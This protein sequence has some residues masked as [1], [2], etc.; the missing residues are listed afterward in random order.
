M[1]CESCGNSVLDEAYVCPF[2]GKQLKT[3]PDEILTELEPRQP[4]RKFY[5][6]AKIFS[7]VATVLSGITLLCG[8]FSFSLL[9]SAFTFG[10]DGGGILA[11]LSAV[12]GI[13]CMVGFAFFAL[14]TGILAFVFKKKSLQPTGVF[15]ILSFIFGVVAFVI[16]V[17]VYILALMQGSLF[18][19]AAFL[20]GIMW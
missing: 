9:W 15:P 19:V 13:L 11:A 6:L 2:C 20:F 3:F 5:R 8:L 14:T 18:G 16:G 1:F 17:V 7:I 12:Y 10:D 4:S